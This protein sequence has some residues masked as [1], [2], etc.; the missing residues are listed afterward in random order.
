MIAAFGTPVETYYDGPFTIM[1]WHKN[2]LSQLVTAPAPARHGVTT[3]WDPARSR[4]RAL[5]PRLT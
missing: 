5:G 4:R 3:A 1:V 2:L